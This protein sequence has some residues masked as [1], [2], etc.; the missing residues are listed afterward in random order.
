M[1]FLSQKYIKKRGRPQEAS[2]TFQEAC[3]VPQ[4]RIC[5]SLT[6]FQACYYQ[7]QSA[8]GEEKRKSNKLLK[9]GP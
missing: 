1:K 3:R 6:A 2:A 5:C 7:F 9:V 4:L 8:K